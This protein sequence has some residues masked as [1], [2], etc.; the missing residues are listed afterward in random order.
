M[1]SVA[2][3]KDRVQ[4]FLTQLGQVTIDDKGRY[5]M[6][7]GSARIFVEVSEL[8]DQT[9]VSLVCPLLLQVPT[10]PALYEYVALHADDYKYGTLSLGL[11]PENSG[12][13]M[14]LFTYGMLGT[15]LD[16]DE[17]KLAVALLADTADDLDNQLQDKFGGRPFHDD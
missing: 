9:W 2:E 15:T 4:R 11:N 16:P 3:T 8:G 17:L 7:N 6:R 14:I 10:S 5:S 12:E 1:A 13:A